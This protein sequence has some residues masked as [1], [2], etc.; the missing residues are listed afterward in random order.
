MGPLTSPPNVDGPDGGPLVVGVDDDRADEVLS[1]LSASTT[2]RVLSALHDEPSTPSALADRLDTSVQNVQ[3]HLGKLR[4]ADLIEAAD[5]V[6]SRKGREMT[7]Y[8]PA[9]STMV[10]VAGGGTNRTTGGLVATLKRLLGGVGVLA[11]ASVA[12]ERLLAPRARDAVGGSAGLQ[13]DSADG[14]GGGGA[15][16]TPEAT[17]AGGATDTAANAGAAGA[18]G[19]ASSTATE[20]ATEAAARTATPT[21]TG[22]SISMHTETATAQATPT[23]ATTPTPEATSTPMPT[24]ETAAEATRV[25]TEAATGGGETVI[26]AVATSPGALFFLGGVTA[27]V[28]V[29]LVVGRR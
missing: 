3:Y 19:G 15:T 14:A 17:T 13:R 23:P 7:V 5:T 21:D 10:L 26:D 11:L 20:A 29:A 2:R 16:G 25:A 9:N 27:L 22:P 24:T 8:A 1:A 4:D 6:Y 18:D 28:L 12:V